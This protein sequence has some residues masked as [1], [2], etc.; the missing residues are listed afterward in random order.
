MKTNVKAFAGHQVTGLDH[1][2]KPTLPDPIPAKTTG[3]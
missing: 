2:F 1:G 3:P